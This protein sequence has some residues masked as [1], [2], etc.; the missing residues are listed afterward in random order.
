LMRRPPGLAPRLVRAL[1]IFRNLR[2]WPRLSRMLVPA[3]S[4]GAFLVDNGGTYF[5]GD[6]GVMIDREVY[7]N[8]GYET[9]NIDLFLASVAPDRRGV[10]LDVGCN[11][12]THSLRFAK[13]FATVHA[14]DPNPALWDQFE[15]NATLNGAGNI[16]LHRVGLGQVEAKLPLYAIDSDNHGLGTFSD[17]PQYDKPLVQIGVARVANGADYVRDLGIDRVDAIKID[18]QGFEGQVLRGFAPIL[19]RD[20]PLVWVEAGG[21]AAGAIQSPEQMQAFFPYKI[22]IAHIQ[23]YRGL[24][25]YGSRLAPAAELLESGDYIVKPATAR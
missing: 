18:V 8:G 3:S 21:Q 9:E 13:M 11:A 14:F 10:I 12:G 4:R 25:S 17:S 15:A 23:G 5:T 20:Q 16:T 22:A 7:L 1:R 2:G 6:L 24:L 19:E